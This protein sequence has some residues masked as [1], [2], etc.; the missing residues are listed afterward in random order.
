MNKKKMD[1]IKSDNSYEKVIRTEILFTPL[2]IIFPIIVSIF[3]IYDWFI[4]GFSVG[5]PAYNGELMLGIII[6]V[7]N[8]IFD[9]LFI[10]SLKTL[11]KG[12][13]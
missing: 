5:N 4:R 12:K 3:L 9:I 13:N 10:K 7:D 8:I 2:L 6:L 11:S 1:Y